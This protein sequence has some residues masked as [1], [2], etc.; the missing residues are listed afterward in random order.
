M[1]SA[2]PQFGDIQTL[3]GG[4]LFW[5]LEGCNLNLDP[6]FYSP[7]DVALHRDFLRRANH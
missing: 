6:L 4:N 2:R 7:A 5:Y 3:Q 1:G